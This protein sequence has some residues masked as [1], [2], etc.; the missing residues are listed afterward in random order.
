M[1]GAVKALC[2]KYIGRPSTRTKERKWWPTSLDYRRM[3]GVLHFSQG[4]ITLLDLGGSGVDSIKWRH[5]LTTIP[6]RVEHLLKRL[7]YYG[8]PPRSRAS[9]A[10]F[11]SRPIMA[12]SLSKTFHSWSFFLNLP[13]PAFPFGTQTQLFGFVMVCTA[14]IWCSLCP[15]V[16]ALLFP[17]VT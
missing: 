1:C 17:I 8:I 14:R 7:R 2:S 15:L 11:Y 6:F 12:Q 3:P 13:K 10:W 9:S 5:H 16:V 4:P